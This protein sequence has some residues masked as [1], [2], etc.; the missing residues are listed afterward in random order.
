[1]KRV[2]IEGPFDEKIQAEIKALDSNTEF[3]FKKRDEI[4]LED[5]QNIQALVGNVNPSWLQSCPNLEWIQLVSAG[6]NQYMDGIIPEHTILTCMSGAYGVAVAEYLITYMLMIMKKIPS[7][8]DNQRE[9]LWHN[10]GTVISPIG[11]R[12][13]VLGTGNIGK[14]FA[15]RAKSLGGYLVGMRRRSG[16]LEYFDE[17]HS[18]KNLKGEVSKA[19]VTVIVLPGTKETYHLF[20]DHILSSCKQGSILMNAGRGNIIDRGALVKNASR[21][22]GVYLDVEENEPLKSDDLLWSI[23]N[24]YITPHI[25]GGYQL[26]FTVNKITDITKHNIKAWL[27][28]GEFISVVDLKSGYAK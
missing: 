16:H 18:I 25:T 2:L 7:Y 11:K 17:V 28:E 24:I 23:K 10:E 8:M 22:K 20:D 1:M 19:D 21:F 15:I 12:I 26:D 14:E 6:A 5:L 27:G 9:G 4:S 3:I 13:L